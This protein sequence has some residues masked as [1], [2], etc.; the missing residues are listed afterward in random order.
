[1]LN[2]NVPG[3]WLAGLKDD[4]GSVK[5]SFPHNKKLVYGQ[6]IL[7]AVVYSAESGE[8]FADYK[9]HPSD[10]IQLRFVSGVVKIVM[11]NTPQAFATTKPFNS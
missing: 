11:V 6:N 4:A 10:K 7:V 8:E 3:P 9:L 2:F 5:V 1:M